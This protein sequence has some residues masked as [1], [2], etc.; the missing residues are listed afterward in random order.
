[1]VPPAP[2]SD[3][4]DAGWQ[5]TYDRIAGSYDW[6]LRLFTLLIEAWEPRERRKLVQRLN[7]RQGQSVLE[8]SVGTGSNLHLLMEAVGTGKIVGLDL[9]QGML[10]QCR[11]KMV[12]LG[13]G[14]PIVRGEAA[15]LPVADESFDAALHYGGINE[16]GDKKLAMDE[17]VRVVKPGGAVVIGDEGLPPDKRNT[18]RSRLLLRFNPLFA[19]EPPMDMLPAGLMD[20]KLEWFWGGAFWMIVG[21]K[22]P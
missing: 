2:A 19:H 9:S 15:H 7:L 5:Q 4:K 3:R 14:A 22:R 8:V 12:R 17:M 10:A 21:H 11:R 6:Q 20:V 16:F 1:M 18:L 13:I